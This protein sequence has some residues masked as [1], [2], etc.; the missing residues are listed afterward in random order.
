MQVKKLF[1]A[2]AAYN[3]KCLHVKISPPLPSS[4]KIMVCPQYATFLKPVTEIR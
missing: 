1:A 4:K 3:K 2:G